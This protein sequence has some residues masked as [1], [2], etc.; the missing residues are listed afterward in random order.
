MDIEEVNIAKHDYA[1]IID[2]SKYEIEDFLG[3]GGVG[4]V[5]GVRDTTTNKTYAMKVVSKK[6]ENFERVKDEA[7]IQEKFKHPGIVQVEFSFDTDKYIIIIMEKCGQ[8][9]SKT[10][11]QGKSISE[12]GALSIF[13]QVVDAIA[14]IHRE[15]Y[16]YRD[17]KTE[18]IVNCGANASSDASSD[19]WKLIDFG[20]AVSKDVL[21][22]Y[23]CCTPDYMA[24]EALHIINEDPYLGQP[25]D[26]WALGV[27]LYEI[28]TGKVPFYKQRLG[29]TYKAIRTE[30]PDYSKIGNPKIIE[31][32]KR[33]LDKNPET[34]AT[35]TEVCDTYKL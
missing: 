11:G 12:E 16:A 31:M 20:F 8:D 25:T 23:P 30:E 28:L 34:R 14:Y 26:V 17:I 22:D 9:L 21:I 35:I 7:D 6:R 2:I 32:L 13:R 19:A 10:G 5:Y 4:K 1:D 24:P 33:M 29:Q 3:R 27:L 15:G 18:N